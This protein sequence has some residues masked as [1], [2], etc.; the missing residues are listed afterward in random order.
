MNLKKFKLEK[1]FRKG[2]SIIIPTWN[3]QVVLQKCLDSI[4]SA[5]P[6][7]VPLELI[8]IDKSSTDNT[9]KIINNW[10]R[11]NKYNF[12]DIP[13]HI[14]TENGV[15]GKAR[16][17]G[18]E[19]S[20]YPTIFWLDSDIVLPKNY[21]EDLFAYTKKMKFKHSL[22]KISMIQGTMLS[23][24]DLA[25][26]FWHNHD[27]D[28]KADDRKYTQISGVPTANLL[29]LKVSLKMN[30][31]EK[32]MLSVLRTGEDSF[33]AI[34]STKNGYKH[35]MYPI[36]TDHLESEVIADEGDYKMLWFLCGYMSS[37]ISKPMALWKLKWIERQGLRSFLATG[38]IRIFIY[39]IN[40]YIKMLRACVKDERIINQKRLRSLKNW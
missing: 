25:S 3:S 18:I 2:C 21:I 11:R 8:I 12:I 14:Y 33:L 10:V 29:T 13:T 38:N 16:L 19:K 40:I 15:L 20:K 1:E 30:K 26:K 27:V 37:G 36:Y 28:K 35:Y 34:I 6:K 23:N 31:K 22:D 4:L 39:T 5:F 17:K 9:K 7:N 32:E 24:N